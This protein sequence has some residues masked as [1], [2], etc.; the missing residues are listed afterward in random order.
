MTNIEKHIQWGIEGGWYGDILGKKAGWTYVAAGTMANVEGFLNI[1][2][3]STGDCFKQLSD[4]QALLDPKFWQAVGKVKGWGDV[5]YEKCAEIDYHE[6]AD[7]G[8]CDSESRYE[9]K[10]KMYRFME[11]I[12]E[13]KTI[14][15]A[16]GLLE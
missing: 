12:A 5:H 14:D 16:L 6:F 9:Y 11:S 1:N 10:Q 4:S 8:E 2:W 7:A 13:H 3:N 15:E